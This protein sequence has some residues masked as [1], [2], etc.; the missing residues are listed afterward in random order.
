MTFL[1]N[2]NVAK[3]LLW[4]KKKAALSS[5]F[6]IKQFAER[7]LDQPQ[8]CL[9]SLVIIIV[10]HPMELILETPKP[11]HTFPCKDFALPSLP[12]TILS[13][14]SSQL[15][16]GNCFSSIFPGLPTCPAWLTQISCLLSYRSHHPHPIREIIL[17]PIFVFHSIKTE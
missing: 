8:Q 4:G 13:S 17:F 5:C 14:L 9:P 2:S 7:Q 1:W 11:S 6:L 16:T 3:W 12:P 10:L 15:L